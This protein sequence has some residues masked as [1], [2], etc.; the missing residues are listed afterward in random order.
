MAKQLRRQSASSAS[1]KLGILCPEIP[2][3]RRH[4]ELR[5]SPSLWLASS[6]SPHQ[7]A[8]ASRSPDEEQPLEMKCH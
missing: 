2:R 8:A 4:V 1:N 6:G 7:A 3:K 5:W